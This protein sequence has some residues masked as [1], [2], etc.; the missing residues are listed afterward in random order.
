MLLEAAALG[1]G[2]VATAAC[3]G[4]EFVQNGDTGI[5]VPVGDPQALADALLRLIQ[6]PAECRHLGERARLKAQAFS[7]DRA[8]GAVLGA[9]EQAAQR[10]SANDRLSADGE[11]A[12]MPADGGP[13]R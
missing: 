10:R 5:S 12:A 13:A 7:W 8:A 1:L 6:N 4:G 2:L 9:Y 3:G 11:A